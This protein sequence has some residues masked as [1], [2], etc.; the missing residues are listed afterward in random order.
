MSSNRRIRGSSRKYID[1]IYSHSR[2]N[3]QNIASLQQNINNNAGLNINGNNE[4]KGNLNI[5]THD[6]TNVND[7]M[8]NGVIKSQPWMSSGLCNGG[9]ITND[10]SVTFNIEAGNGVIVH[11]GITCKIS[12]DQFTAEPIL[13]GNHKTVV[14]I[15]CNGD[16]FKQPTTFTSRQTRQYI[17][18]GEV[19]HVNQSTIDSIITMP[20]SLVSEGLQLRDLADAIG[21]FNITGNIFSCHESGNLSISKTSGKVYQHGSNVQTV[22]GEYDPSRILQPSL[23]A[24][25]VTQFTQWGISTTSTMLNVAQWDSNGTIED[26]DGK[27]NNYTVQ[28]IYMTTHNNIAVAYGQHVYKNEARAITG[29]TNDDYN[30]ITG[31][32]LLLRA[33]LVVHRD[34]TDLTDVNQARFI[35]AG[36]FGIGISGRG[37]ATD[38]DILETATQFQSATTLPDTTTFNSIVAV[39]SLMV[40]GIPPVL[41]LFAQTSDHTTSSTSEGLAGTGV[42]SLT[43][44]ANT[45]TVGDMFEFHV[46][47]IHNDTVGVNTTRWRLAAGVTGTTQILSTNAMTLAIATDK[48]FDLKVTMCIRSIGAAGVANAQVSGIMITKYDG[49]SVTDIEHIEYSSLIATVFDTTIDNTLTVGIIVQD[50]T[51]QTFTSKINTLTKIR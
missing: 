51:S 16:V 5:G 17:V 38:I 31:G 44:P 4:M 48:Y 40:D 35:S 13:S 20:H 15:D 33:Y 21:L 7:I 23:S 27:N 6:I 2:D 49:S 10:T 19:G 50:E 25:V 1:S 41:T 30:D 39:K 45:M 26:I 46:A 37:G 12:W 9:N 43:I 22:D 47:G 36:R 3:K 24:P 34:A 28:R 29:I 8:I 32:N 18:L 11:N 14:G 42:G